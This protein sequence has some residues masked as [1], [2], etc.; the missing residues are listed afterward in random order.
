MYISISTYI[1]PCPSIIRHKFFVQNCVRRLEFFVMNIFLFNCMHVFMSFTEPTCQTINCQCQF[2]M[3]AFCL[4]EKEKEKE[5][6]KKLLGQCTKLASLRMHSSSVWQCHVRKK[7]CATWQLT[8][9][10]TW[11]GG[12]WEITSSHSNLRKITNAHLEWVIEY[13]AI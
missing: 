9:S 7:R 3:L 12:I 2:G 1:I 10:Y 6:P 8:A 13:P 4:K 11:T 5:K